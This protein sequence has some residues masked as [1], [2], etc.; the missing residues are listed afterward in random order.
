MKTTLFL[1]RHA[2][3]P[4]NLLHLA[5]LQGRR[6]DPPLAPLGVRQAEITR[7]FLAV[8]PIDACYCSP[9]RRAQDTAALIVKPRGLKA[10]SIDDLTE[11]D[12]GRWEGLD[13]DTIRCRDPEGYR[14]FHANPVKFGYPGGESFGDVYERAAPV[15]D[16]LVE[17]HLGGTVLVVTHHV[18]GRTY[19]AGILGLGP[20]R[21]RKI[22]LDNCGISIVETQGERKSLVTLNATFHLQGLG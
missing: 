15:I 5:K 16:R 10:Q 9:M 19:L 22:S 12:V 17:E 18:V 11:C 21:G 4:A 7:D 6:H 2:A 1:L 14:E 3:T 8:R 20:E 13:W